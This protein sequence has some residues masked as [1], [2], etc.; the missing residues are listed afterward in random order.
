MNT[1]NV[2]YLKNLHNLLGFGTKLNHV[3]DSA[4]AR[5][6]QSFSLGISNYHR[7]LENNDFNG[8]KTDFVQYQLNYSRGNDGESYFLNNMAVTLHKSS[9]AQPRYHIFDLERDHRITALQAYKLLS[10]LSLLKEIYPKMKEGE[11][12]LANQQTIP[13]WFKLNLDITNAYGQH[14]LRTFYPEHGFDLS[15]VLHKYPLTDKNNPKKIEEILKNLSYG[16]Y[17]HLEMKIGKKD[18]PAIIS[19]NPQYK[20]LDIYDKNM[21]EIRNDLLFSVTNV[22]RKELSYAQHN[23]PEIP[24]IL[25]EQQNEKKHNR[26][27]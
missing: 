10:G 20:S 27:R 16:N 12:R 4:I 25:P 8:Q 26:S 23:L 22:D 6:L 14:P 5:D 2:E 11:P 21:V 1:Y 9:L 17:Q 7:P 24:Q 19:A 15:T 13:V 18:V 3:L